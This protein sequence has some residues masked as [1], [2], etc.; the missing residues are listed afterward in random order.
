MRIVT[1]GGGTGSHNV[2]V[3]LKKHDC[4]ITAV[5]AMSDSGGSSGRLRDELGQLPPGDVR[6]CLVALIPE[7]RESILYRNFFNYRFSTGECLD[8][9]NFGNLFLAALADVTGSAGAAIEEA[10]R[11][12]RIRGR[13]L[14]VNL[15]DTTLKAQLVDGTEI[16]GESNLDQRQIRPEVLIDYVFLDPA[17]YAHQ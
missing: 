15:T 4:E 1:I 12:L 10:S 7:E 5:V 16:V 14:P 3:G 6:Q 9:H 2:L 8:G 17:A 13:V 11:I